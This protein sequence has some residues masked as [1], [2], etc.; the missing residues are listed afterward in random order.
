MDNRFTVKTGTFEGP[1]HLLLDLIEKRKLLINDVSLA[2]VADDFIAYL[3]KQADFPMKDSADFILVASTLLLIKSKSLLPTLD[4]TSEEEGDIANLEL[5]L[6]LYQRFRELAVHLRGIFGQTPLF[7]PEERTRAVVFSPH[8]RITNEGL[9]LAVREAMQNVPRPKLHPNVSI[10]KVISL[11]DMI[12]RL[13]DRVK[14]A[15]SMSFR[16]FS[17]MGKKEKVEV[18]V[19]FL[20]MLEL[21]KRGVLLVKQENHF[22]DITIETEALSVPSYV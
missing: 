12:V 14:S 3:E 22:D 15:L 5:R 8:K 7:A 9:L 11:E 6:K 2:Q 16:D 20:A 18:I 19:S 21:V 4:L 17:G 13:S 1:L 10:K